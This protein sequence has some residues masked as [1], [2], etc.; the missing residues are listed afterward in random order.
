MPATKQVPKT[1]S[2]PSLGPVKSIVKPDSK[3]KTPHTRPTLT[4]TST[5]TPTPEP[6][7][8]TPIKYTGPKVDL[9]K[10]NAWP[11]TKEDKDRIHRFVW[12]TDDLETVE[13][14][15]SIRPHVSQQFVWDRYLAGYCGGFETGL[16]FQCM[17]RRLSDAIRYG[18]RFDRGHR[19]AFDMLLEIVYA[20]RIRLPLD[21]VLDARECGVRL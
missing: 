13:A 14:E 20:W 15:M 19:V 6:R 17:R 12:K 9:P 21:I 16:I 4:S 1:D 2:K 7:T 5:P 10:D 11:F 8:F 3:S 18:R